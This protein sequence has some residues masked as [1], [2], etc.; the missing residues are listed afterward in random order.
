MRELLRLETQRWE[1]GGGNVS[2]EG[3]IKDGAYRKKWS[4][5]VVAKMK[6]LRDKALAELADD[7]VG[8]QRFL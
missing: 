7:P 2:P 5:E 6:G 3:R 4:P 8:R 1:K